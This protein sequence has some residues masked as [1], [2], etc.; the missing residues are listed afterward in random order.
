M[1]EYVLVPG[2]RGL[3]AAGSAGVVGRPVSRSTERAYGGI[4][5]ESEFTGQGVLD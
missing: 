4:T 3:N 2:K 1:I 5:S